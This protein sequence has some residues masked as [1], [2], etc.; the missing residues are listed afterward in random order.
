MA[1]IPMRT[2]GLRRVLLHDYIIE[3]SKKPRTTGRELVKSGQIVINSLMLKD[4][5]G[6]KARVIVYTKRRR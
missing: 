2:V 6:E 4:M 3:E 1:K 5:I